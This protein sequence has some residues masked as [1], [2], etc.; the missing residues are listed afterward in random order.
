M[1]SKDDNVVQENP[2]CKKAGHLE[3]TDRTDQPEK[4]ER[5]G[6]ANNPKPAKDKGE[7]GDEMKTCQK[8]LDTN[9]DQCDANAIVSIHKCKNK[10]KHK[11][12]KV[13]H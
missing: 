6:D 7:T 8:H 10:S 9:E 12:K 11:T 1:I 3:L 2:V 5:E 13:S 4:D